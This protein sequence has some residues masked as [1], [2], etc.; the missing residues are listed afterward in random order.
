MCP[1]THIFLFQNFKT[2]LAPIYIVFYRS[3]TK[4][5]SQSTWVQWLHHASRDGKRPSSSSNCKPLALGTRRLVKDNEWFGS[6]FWTDWVWN[7]FALREWHTGLND[8]SPPQNCICFQPVLFFFRDNLRDPPTTGDHNYIG[9]FFWEAPL[10]KRIR[11]G[12]FPARLTALYYS[13][14]TDIRGHLFCS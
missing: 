10:W 11:T 12:V 13:D 3:I 1:I 4:G 5:D 8:T 2:E 14:Y 9:H 7:L 6:W